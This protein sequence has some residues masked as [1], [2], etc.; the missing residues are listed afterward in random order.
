MAKANAGKPGPKKV[1]DELPY[2]SADKCLG[3]PV[4]NEPK[5]GLGEDY[6]FS[7]TPKQTS[8]KDEANKPT[9]AKGK[10]Y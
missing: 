7:G 3:G 5:K 6:K 1:G 8:V 4:A 2:A 10:V 9:Q